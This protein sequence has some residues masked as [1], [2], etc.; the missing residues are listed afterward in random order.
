MPRHF[1]I[2]VNGKLYRMTIDDHHTSPDEFV[3]EEIP[4]IHGGTLAI[5]AY[6]R[7]GEIDWNAVYDQGYYLAILKASEGETFLDPRFQQNVAEASNAGLLTQFYHFGRPDRIRRA[8]D[9]R[10]TGSQIL[11]D[12]RE[13]AQLLLQAVTYDGFPV[14]DLVYFHDG[15]IH[16]PVRCHGWLDLEKTVGNLNEEQGDLWLE[17]FCNRCEDHGLWLGFYGSERWFQKEVTPHGWEAFA[18][19]FR[20]MPWGVRPL[21]VARY[22][23]NDGQVP[24]IRK[25]SPDEK[26]PPGWT[27]SVWQ[28]T[29]QGDIEGVPRRCDLNIAKIDWRRHC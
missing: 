24:D 7:T 6:H 11:R 13:E 29:S 20:N 27:W 2:P 5:D 15:T 3:F 23:R 1:R 4:E 12:A 25:Y 26:V 19:K 18:S 8:D 28:Y 21:W 10:V 14:T 9:K 16:S 22:G 17:R